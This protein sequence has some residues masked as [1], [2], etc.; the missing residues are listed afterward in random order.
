MIGR[1]PS[2]PAGPRAAAEKWTTSP[3][4]AA[5]TPPWILNSVAGKV[6]TSNMIG[7]S[8]SPSTEAVIVTPPVMKAVTS[9][10][11]LTV[12]TSGSDEVHVIEGSGRRVPS[13]WKTAG[14]CAIIVPT[15]SRSPEAFRSTRSMAGQVIVTGIRS[16][17]GATPPAATTAVAMISK[18][19]AENAWS[20]PS[21]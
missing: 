2:S 19:P 6:A 3:V 12:A 7:T 4:R 21:R 17:S 11:R 18:S 16:G 14:S 13:R 10:Y 5:S 1:S 15:K 8:I 9:P 20:V